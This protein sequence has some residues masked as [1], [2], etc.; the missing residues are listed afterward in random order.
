[1]ERFMQLRGVVYHQIILNVLELE[2]LAIFI[3]AEK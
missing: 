2:F 1:M 3:F